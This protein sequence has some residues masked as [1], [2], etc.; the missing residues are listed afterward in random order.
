MPYEHM[1]RN[2]RRRMAV[3]AREEAA[4]RP[5]MLTE[6]PKDRW[7]PSYRLGPS[8]PV[9]AYES[10]QYLAQLYDVGSAEGRTA[11][12]LSVCR[13]TLRDDGRWEE[14]LSWDEL[15]QVKRE[16]GFADMYAVEIYPRDKDIVDVA[17]MRHL[18]LL[19]TPLSLGWFA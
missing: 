8:A 3:L 10:R 1:N 15:M 19:A 12:R 9:K 7:P 13:V 2:D 6:I 14:G 11:M 17:N 4:K 16:C 5:V 18:W